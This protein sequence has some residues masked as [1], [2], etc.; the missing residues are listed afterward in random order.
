MNLTKNMDKRLIITFAAAMMLT[1]C[2]STGDNDGNSSSDNNS[3]S[4]FTSQIAQNVITRGAGTVGGV[5]NNS[6]E[7]L[8][9]QWNGETLHVIMTKH[10][11]IDYARYY[12]E[13]GS[14]ASEGDVIYDGT[15][16]TAPKGVST[17]TASSNDGKL[18][19][20]PVQGTFDFW[21]YYTDNAT[22]NT[23]PVLSDDG[24]YYYVPF[25][26]DG[27]QDLM[28]ATT[29]APDS[30]LLGSK[31]S[32]DRANFYSAYS[33]RRNVQPNLLFSH[34]L[35]RLQFSL[36]PWSKR[37]TLMQVTKIVLKSRTTGKLIVAYNSQSAVKQTA[38]FDNTGVKAL[39]VKNRTNGV[40]SDTL[41]WQ[42]PLWADSLKGDSALITN[43]GEAII[44]EPRQKYDIIISYRQPPVADD[45]NHVSDAITQQWETEMWLPSGEAFKEGY[46]Y[47]VII[48]VYRLMPIKLYATLLDFW[49]SGE[50]INMD[51]DN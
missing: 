23:K 46:S 13:I 6:T 35:T 4:I 21:G 38:V 29:T 5:M 20:Y 43:I 48:K 18:K 8:P 31:G 34:K 37:D 28:T 14:T 30:S 11:T 24:T 10:G 16:F 9:N 40:L 7:I 33:A 36:V 19:Y 12:P 47:N 44:V 51:P 25:S 49:K 26:I 39:T 45:P 2:S 15:A 41:A 22:S 42:H 3:I 27:S 17:G 50:D 32:A 1:A